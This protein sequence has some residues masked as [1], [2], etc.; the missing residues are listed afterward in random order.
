MF[1][2]PKR[3]Q[4][5]G[6]FL[7]DRFPK[8]FLWK[9]IE[10]GQVGTIYKELSEKTKELKGTQMVSW[11][12]GILRIKVKSSV[13]RQE[14]ILKREKLLRALKEKGVEVKETKII[15]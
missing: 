9:A 11:R 15:F 14:I 13:Q 4:R 7:S 8:R 1:Q 6:S 12:D 3:V 2:K 10:A 5:L